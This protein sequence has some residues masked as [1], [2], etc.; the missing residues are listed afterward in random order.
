MYSI[1]MMMQGDKLNVTIADIN[2]EGEGVVR[3]GSERFVLFVPDALPGE[4]AEVRV[5]SKKKN[6]GTAKLLERRSTSPDRTAP[7]CPSFGRCGGCQLQHIAYNAQLKMKEKTVRDALERIGGFHAP[8][9]APCEPSP[10]QWGYRNKAS[11]PVQSF[12]GERVHAGF[13][14][15]R[16]HEIIPYTQCAVLDPKINEIA[17]A[18]LA[19]L[20]EAGFCGVREGGGPQSGLLRHVVIRQA[21]FTED[22]LV[23]VI[24]SRA[25][26][27]AETRRLNTVAKKIKGLGGL[28]YNINAEPGNFIWGSRTIPIF[29]ASVM[30]ER[31]GPYKFTF[32]ASSFFQ[33][34]SE[35]AA[36]LYECAAKLALADS[37]KNILELYSGTGS[38]T[39]FLAANGAA[40]TAVESWLP[41]AKYIKTNAE[42]NGITTITHKAAQAE[43]IAEELSRGSYDTVVVDPPRTGCDEKVIAAIIKISPKR[44][45]YVSCNP[46]TLARDA[47]KLAQAGY[48]LQEAH[49]FD[50]FPETGHVETVALMSKANN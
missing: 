28:V 8:K 48:D 44:V 18:L 36:A 21:R 37:P 30:T 26:S 6:Y 42:Q 13:Y 23:A 17:R 50:M 27:D 35:Q 29:G 16:S 7:V 19:A 31:L 3:A 49:P 5:V 22:S 45:V 46:A 2:N 47:A 14:K 1:A 38:L 25:L 34:N 33:V 24:G 43:D 4:E 10:S 32:E 20:K 15:K 40:V 39:V 9:V 12:C 41:A 11:L